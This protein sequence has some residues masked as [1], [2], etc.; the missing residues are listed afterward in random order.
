MRVTEKMLQNQVDYLNELTGNPPTSWTR[1]DGRNRANIGNYHL[2][3]AYGGV[4]L[5]QVTN[6]GGGVKTPIGGGCVP[7]KELHGKLSAFIEG[8]ELSKNK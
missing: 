7:K 6:E 8:I 4:C 2:Y 3:F 1:Q 5:H